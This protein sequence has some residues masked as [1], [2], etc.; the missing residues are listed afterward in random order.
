MKQ[1]ENGILLTK[2]QEL[3]AQARKACKIFGENR[4]DASQDE[5]ALPDLDELEDSE[6]E[7]ENKSEEDFDD[8][9][10]YTLA[11]IVNPDYIYNE[12]AEQWRISGE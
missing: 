2:C 12:V 7:E 3:P 1:W 8:E 9:K 11:V 10:A 5:N 4:D 6:D